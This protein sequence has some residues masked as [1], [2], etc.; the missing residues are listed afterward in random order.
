MA[1]KF[2]RE[3]GPSGRPA[4]N[5]SYSPP[6]TKFGIG[7]RPE[8]ALAIARRE[9]LDFV[10]IV[11]DDFFDTARLPDA[12]LEVVSRGVEVIPHC[13]SLSLGGAEQVDSS[14]IRKLDRVAS[15]CKSRM[16]SDHL[17]FVRAGGIN[18]GHLLPV[19]YT[20]DE[21]E[22]LVENI[23]VAKTHLQVP[24]AL[25]NIANLFTWPEAEYSESEFFAEVL[26]SAD[27]QML[28]DVSNLYANSQNHKFDPVKYLRC[29]PLKRLAYV[30]VAGGTVK[31]GLY[32]DTHGHSIPQGALDL[33]RELAGLVTIPAVMLERDSNFPKQEELYAE[34]DAIQEAVR[35]AKAHPM[36]VAR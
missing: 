13:V 7:W 18:S 3:Q 24:L 9:T 28:L 14:V 1:V 35:S 27:I 32:H 5:E 30:H 25:E 10:E 29:L 12:L 26:N 22:I 17:T 4:K 34:L 21:V 15:L 20:A 19:A 16:V 11:A 8:L 2:L 31:N 23:I 6:A 36:V 33:L